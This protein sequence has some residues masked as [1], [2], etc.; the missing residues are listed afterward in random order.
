M[1]DEVTIP[2]L[3]CPEELSSLNPVAVIIP[4]TCY[5]I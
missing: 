3:I 2:A 1:F 4:D 5:V